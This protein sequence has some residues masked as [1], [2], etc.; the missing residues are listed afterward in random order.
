MKKRTAWVLIAA[1]AAVSLGAAAVG[2]VALVL[3]GARPTAPFTASNS[4]L[5]LNLSGQIPEEPPASELPAF[6]ERRPPSLRTLVESL[7]RAARDPRIQ[8]VVLRVSSLPD[9]GFGKVQELRDA[10][11]RFRKSG[12]PVYAHLESAGNKEFYLAAS[13]DKIFAVPTAILD[14]T[15]LAAE[16]T[17]SAPFKRS[18]SSSL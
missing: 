3:R 8:S 15:G 12:K 10:I 2:A 6:F 1:V 17:F 9:A 7:E 5:S 4:Y 13:C 18:S 11:S 14:V 16:V